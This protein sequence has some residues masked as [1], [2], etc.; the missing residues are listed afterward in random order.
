MC[1]PVIDLCD[2]S[3]R[4]ELSNAPHAA[5]EALEDGDSADVAHMAHENQGNTIAG[6]SPEPSALFPEGLA[7][8][9]VRLPRGLEL[10]ELRLP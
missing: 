6:P 4:D 1:I 9:P 3:L 10:C 5:L 2:D 8:P 7:W